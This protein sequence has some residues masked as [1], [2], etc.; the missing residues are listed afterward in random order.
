M[1]SLSEPAATLRAVQMSLITLEGNIMRL[2]DEID[3]AETTDLLQFA[4]DLHYVKSFVS[5]LFNEVQSN[6]TEHIGNL[7]IPI[8]VDGATIEIKSGSPRK[9]W[10][11][12]SLIDAVS[13]RLVD[14][15]VDLNTGEVVKTPT[16]MIRE[17]L[18]FAGIS[19]WKVSKLKELHLDADDYCEVGE[20]K[21]SLVIRRDK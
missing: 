1:S 21:K 13:K 14:S 5:Q 12:R 7:P 4:S 2:S 11:H 10:D 8:E 9:T 16:S 17:A 20:A 3:S 18:E 6:I 19:Y 15:S